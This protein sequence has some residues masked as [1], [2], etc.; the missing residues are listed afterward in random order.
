[1]GLSFLTP[2]F[3]AGFIAVAVPI[4]IH[5][6]RRH[7]GK[8][9]RFPSLMF[10]RQLPVQSVRRRTIRDWPL[11]LLRIGA[12]VLIALAFARP[13]L[14]L[15][16]SED[17]LAQDALRE[18]VIVLDR[19]WSMDRGERWDRALADARATL[20]GLVTPDRASLV[21]FD[22]VG[23][24]VVEPT[25][26]PGRVSAALDTLRPGWGGTQIGAG[27]QAASGI[28]QASDRTQREVV[29]ISD[30]QRRGWEAGPRD[31]L[32][33]GTR[34]ITRDVGDDGLG[35]M[36]VSD[37]TL[38]HSFAE[39]RQRV[40]PVAR[41]VR[42][43][44]EAPTR[45]R[46][47]L[48]IDGQETETRDVELASEGATAVAFDPIT[49][50][51]EGIRGAV[52]LE[53]EGSDAMEPFRFVVSP[54]E[55]LSVL[56]LEGG[57]GRSAA[58]YL[59][60]ALTVAGGQPIRVET[61]SDGAISSADLQGTDL[62]VLNDVPL[63]SGASGSLLRDHISAGG[64]LLVIAGPD[65]DPAGWDS[66]W[67]EYLPGRVGDIVERDPSTAASLAQVD[68]DHPVFSAFQGVAGSGLGTPRFFR[69]RELD[70]P[71]APTGESSE[72]VPPADDT[73]PRVL[74]RF[75]DGAPA[76]A[77]RIVGAGRVLLW[78][79]T[80]DNTWSDIPLHPVFLPLVREAVQFAAGTRER[81]PYFTV[82]QPLD[83]RFLLVEAGLLRE[84][85]DAPEDVESA[86]ATGL[87]PSSA[88]AIARLIAP[89]GT[90]TELTGSTGE[91][92]K[93]A[94]PGFYEVREATDD[95]GE[96]WVLAVNPDVQEADPTRIDPEEL[97]LAVAPESVTEGE[98]EP[99][100]ASGEGDLSEGTNARTLLEEGER[101]QSAWRFLLAGA[102]LLLVGEAV[103]AGRR[104]PLAKQ[105]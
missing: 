72:E 50:P 4:I 36:I 69:Y 91:L 94:S 93:L 57:R 2:L 30:F 49:L 98:G 53:P 18:S 76:L 27:L 10:L 7:R 73:Q 8:V 64:G 14:R 61:R 62:V 102:L 89:D 74:A 43:G 79:S 84:S 99:R 96:G 101:R 22:G 17:G 28:L 44:E 13:V 3:L 40:R 87:E 24:V 35:A 11:L 66:A 82:G 92:V 78:T 34:F 46:I 67:D 54:S 85:E 9:V 47:A 52:V 56:L 1:M 70:V 58:P 38:E 100:V 68:R 77:Q 83:S 33:E 95:A 25:L 37:V 39:N 12:L 65:S 5:L 105:A 20:D 41:V 23:S 26:D 32:P 60:N 51:D 29:L 63:P 103:L 90:A 31:P 15:G 86:Q 55:I 19:S 80:L 59:R 16:G 88:P 21:L 6:I 45:A 75:D 81:V 48:E 71:T 97:T 104:K 42:Q